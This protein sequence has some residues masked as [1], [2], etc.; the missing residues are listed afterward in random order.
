MQ[1]LCATTQM[2]IGRPTHALPYWRHPASPTK[3]PE[4][5][6]PH[7]RY[8]QRPR[9]HPSACACKDAIFGRP[10]GWTFGEHELST[11]HGL[12]AAAPARASPGCDRALLLAVSVRRLRLR[13]RLLLLLL[14]LLPLLPLLL[15]LRLGLR[16][17]LSTITSDD[18]QSPR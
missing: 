1:T 9:L 13:L 6:S 7:S 15:L 14:L 4:R 3:D 8:L 11:P 17:M 18:W 2:S 16:R 12:R 5:T 10:Q